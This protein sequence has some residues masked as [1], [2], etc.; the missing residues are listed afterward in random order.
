MQTETPHESLPESHAPNDDDALRT[1][2]SDP[3]IR[4]LVKAAGYAALAAAGEA[5][6]G[7]SLLDF[8]G[9]PISNA[10]IHAAEFS[11]FCGRMYEA[12]LQGVSLLGACPKC[13]GREM[14]RGTCVAC[15]LPPT[16]P[17]ALELAIR[18]I[19]H[20]KESGRK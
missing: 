8:L 5:D 9:L 20:E 1:G 11:L 13:G 3:H 17:G 12:V 15:G 6:E 18:H 10:G 19:S 7:G 14:F 4:R 16:G 2:L